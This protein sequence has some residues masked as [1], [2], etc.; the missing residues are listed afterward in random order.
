MMF[1]I[2][3][4][5]FRNNYFK[6]QIINI[7]LIFVIFL[8]A[9]N[10]SKPVF[11]SNCYKQIAD[12]IYY[13]LQDS[14][15][16]IK[17]KILKSI[18][19]NNF[20]IIKNN[21]TGNYC[22]NN[23]VWAKDS[24]NVYYKFHKLSGADPLS[25]KVLINGYSKDKNKIY[26][27]E[28]LIFKADAKTFTP[29]GDFYAKDKNN[30]WFCEKR[31][32]GNFDI[33]N[34]EII[35]GYF[36]KDKHGIYLNNDFFVNKISG[37]DNQTFKEIQQNTEKLLCKYYFD[38]NNI[39]FIDTEKKFDDNDFF[40]VINID[41]ETFKITNSKHYIKSDLDIYYKNKK[42]ESVDIKSFKVLGKNYSFDKN[43][44][45]YKNKK[46]T[47]ADIKSFKLK[48]SENYDACDFYKCYLK[49]EKISEK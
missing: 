29:L 26:F 25:F 2:R 38:K 3:N 12:K 34:F 28:K 49:G 21:I 6:F 42:I 1:K 41:A 37:A 46:I 47:G 7:I 11:N 48:K 9:C 5:K 18:N 30:I 4:W 10:N 23:D 40:Y 15:G 22:I 35:D 16:M 32:S 13:I 39:Y 20:R 19:P 36:S 31:V 14:S 24:M 44:V 8:L 33:K 43:Y 45:Y 27:R 17:K